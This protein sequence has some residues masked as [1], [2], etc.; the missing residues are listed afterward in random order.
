VYTYIYICI[1]WGCTQQ[2]APQMGGNKNTQLYS[3][4]ISKYRATC[5][6]VFEKHK[7]QMLYISKSMCLCLTH[8][9][10]GTI[11]NQSGVY[12]CLSSVVS[13]T[14]L[15]YS[16]V[17]TWK[18]NLLDFM[19]SIPCCPLIAPPI[20]FKQM[21]YLSNNSFQML[22]LLTNFWTGRKFPQILQTPCRIG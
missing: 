5:M 22:H 12:F 17:Q 15:T 20:M 18:T 16:L 13:N 9:S 21:G 1:I 11:L 4:N 7:T 2:W 10:L 19:K 6:V 14:T 8:R 3:I